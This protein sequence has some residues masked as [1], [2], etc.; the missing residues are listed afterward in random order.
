VRFHKSPA[1]HRTANG[2]LVYRPDEYSFD[3][4]P[5]PA[6]F[7]SILVNDLSLEVDRSGRVVS[8]WGLC[9]H[10]GWQR[11]ELSPPPADVRD[12]FVVADTPLQGG[13]S[14]RLNPEQGW[15]MLADSESGWVCV[16]SGRTGGLYAEILPGVVL[17]LDDEGKLCAVWLRPQ[18]FPK[19][20]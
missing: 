2:V 13:I 5:T 10:P 1:S 15:S 4:E 18:R 7:T 14:Q 9:P 16:T 6:G 19:L 3:V 20:G 17:D 12:I 8:V 11:A